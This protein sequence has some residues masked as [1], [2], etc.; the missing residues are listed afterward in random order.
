M[1][2]ARARVSHVFST[3]HFLYSILELPFTDSDEAIEVAMLSLS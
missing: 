1:R 3:D 2:M